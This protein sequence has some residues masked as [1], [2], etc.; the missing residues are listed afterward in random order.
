MK[1]S[2]EKTDDKKK[3]R[4]G[5]V[6]PLSKL[7]GRIAPDRFSFKTTDDLEP[8][9]GTIGQERGVRAI[10]FALAHGTPGFNCYV[11]G[12]VGT[13]RMTS[14]TSLVRRRARE[15]KSPLDW[16]YVYNF[17]K[18]SEPIPVS[19]KNGTAHVFA[20]KM[21]EFVKSCRNELP[22]IFDSEEYQDELKKVAAKY[23]ERKEAEFKKLTEEAQKRDFMIQR[24]PTG[25][26]PIPIREGKP[27]EQEV[28]QKLPKEEQEKVR[29]A[30]QEL[31][32]IMEAILAEVRRIETELI[33]ALTEYDRKVAYYALGLLLNPLMEEHKKETRISK[34]FNWVKRDI[35]KHIDL[36]KKTDDQEK[37]AH[38]R[39]LLERYQVNVFVDN[40]QYNGAPVIFEDNPTYYNLFGAIEY[41]NVNGNMVTDFSKIKPGGVHRA[42]GGYLLLPAREL[43]AQPFAWEA[44]KRTLLSNE[45]KIENISEKVRGAIIETLRPQPI[46]VDFKV[47]IVG[48]PYIYS[49]LHELDEDFRRLFKVRA[50]FDVDMPRDEENEL[51]YARFIAARC[52]YDGLRPFTREAVTS[53]IEYGSRAAADQERLSTRFLQISDLASEASFWAM[54][55]GSPVVKPE[56]IDKAL[57]ENIYRSSLVEEK[58]QDLM[59]RGT[60]LIDV[61]GEKVGEL[62]GL[63]VMTLGD[64]SFGKPV[65]ITARTWLGKKGVLQIERE[66][67]MSGPIHNKGVL[68][69]TGYLGGTFAGKHPLPLSA[70]L[71]FEQLYDELEGDS[72]SSTELY[73][74]LSSLSGVPLT[75]SIAVTGSVNQYGVVQPIGGANEKIE[76]FFSLCKAKGL[77]GGQGVMIPAPNVTNLML[78]QEV[79]DAVKADKFHIYAV[80]TIEQG[81]EV[82]TGVT[83][84]EVFGKVRKRLASMHEYMKEEKGEEK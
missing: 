24:G 38:L 3:M 4:E 75:Q 15:E 39:A 19:L 43:L 82:L 31:T 76:G 17:E 55:A 26:F 14:V 22:K 58:L 67:R 63:T 16:V 20:T 36:F 41:R 1:K 33:E 13:G 61:D 47:I 5:R 68:I 30:G 79:L 59:L 21:D 42:N 64:F 27:L 81:I 18:P 2:P 25:L 7:R 6:V 54:D 28:F 83:A 70:S 71:T 44:L 80:Q 60:L 37:I 12:P 45:A 29:K 10:R 66:T 46:P 78:R 35:V 34:Y 8:L 72:A 65:K 77:T 56:H 23:E 84:I 57:E 32:E 52:K 62:N 49:L 73:A 50:D 51:A 53:M 40:S 74:L 69:I 11:S 9:H 48:S